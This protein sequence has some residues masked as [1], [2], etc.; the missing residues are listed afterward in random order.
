MAWREG[1]VH[2]LYDRV[3][4]FEADGRVSELVRRTAGWVTSNMEES[5]VA[6]MEK[7]SIIGR[8]RQ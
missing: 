1:A 5:G 6:N 3:D 2:V 4:R 7:W 8:G